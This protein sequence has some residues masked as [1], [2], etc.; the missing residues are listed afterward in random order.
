MKRESLALGCLCGVVLTLLTVSLAGAQST[1][2]VNFIVGKTDLDKDT[3]PA[4][5]QTTFGVQWSFGNEGWPVMLAVDLI[6]SNGD[7]SESGGYYYF[8]Y[9]YFDA[10]LDVDVTTME[11]AFGVRKE[12]GKK[13]VHPFIGG[14][15]QWTDTDVDADLTILSLGSASIVDDS[16]SSVGFWANA[17]IYWRLGKHFNLGVNVRYRDSEATLEGQVPGTEI[18][19]DTSGV[20]Y[21]ALLGWGW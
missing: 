4:D 21:G 6:Y 18:D 15:L 20:H 10:K 7:G 12:W 1:G 8:P 16:D 11:L 19:I 17:G 9:G 5:D 3:E 2:S 13:S 14:G